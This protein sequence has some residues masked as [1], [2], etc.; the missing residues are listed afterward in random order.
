MGLPTGSYDNAKIDYCK[1]HQKQPFILRQTICSSVAFF[2]S[3]SFQNMGVYL[4]SLSP[5]SHMPSNC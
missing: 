4:Q 3:E 2:S 5:G 1:E